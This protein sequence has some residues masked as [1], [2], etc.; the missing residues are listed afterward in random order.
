VDEADD[1][2]AEDDADAALEARRRASMSVKIANSARNPI[3]ARNPA[4]TSLG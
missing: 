2:F 1:G 4:R 3:P